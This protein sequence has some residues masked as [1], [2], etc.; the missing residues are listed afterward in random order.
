M[1][2]RIHVLLIRAGGL[3]WALPMGNVEE[4]FDMSDRRVHVVGPSQCLVFRGNVVELH[5]LAD[6]LGLPAGE[7]DRAAALIVWAGGRRRAFAVSELVGQLEVE[8]TDL[9]PL[10]RNCFCERAAIL[11]E[12]DVVPLLDPSAVVGVMAAGDGALF[13]LEEMQLS[14]LG[15]L[16][17]IGSG[18][19]ATAL[20]S[21]LGQTV[22]IS[23]PTVELITAAGAADAIG[24]PTETWV[25][26][27]TPVIGGGAV[28]LLFSKDGARGLAGLLGT[29]LDSDMGLSALGEVGNILTASYLTAIGQ[30]TGHDLDLATPH[31]QMGMLGHLL[32]QSLLALAGPGVAT[33][34]IRSGMDVVEAGFT[35]LYVPSESHVRDLLGALGLGLPAAA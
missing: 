14:A 2:D 19:A 4:T 33:L 8:L 7:D 34:L 16:A 15:E 20:A 13:D 21:L 6:A 9:P 1:A 12:G 25:V 22:D 28:F 30:F 18:N 10:T 26:V 29:T 5:G 23:C 27:E 17:N 3:L 31:V 32:E 35:F 11:D 24:H